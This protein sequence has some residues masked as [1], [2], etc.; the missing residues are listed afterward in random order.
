MEST[1][2]ETLAVKIQR[3]GSTDSAELVLR[4]VQAGEEESV[5]AV[6]KFGDARVEAVGENYFDALAS[7]RRQLEKTGAMIRC[8]GSAVNVFPSPMALSMG[9]GR[10]AYR[11]TLGQQARQNDLVDIFAS[12]PDDVIL[13]SVDDQEQFYEKWLKSLGRAGT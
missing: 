7:V 11:L 1:D 12:A 3:E 13:G 4:V 6:L 9:R 10:K 2:T 5:R 8:Y